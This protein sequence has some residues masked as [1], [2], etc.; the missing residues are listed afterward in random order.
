MARSIS[1]VRL[2]G[3]GKVG[4]LLAT[5]L[6]DSGFAVTAYDFRERRDLPFRTRTLDVRDKAALTAALLGSD[7]VVSCVPY[8]LTLPVA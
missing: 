8:H 2:L 7:A 3:L 6:I 1:D 4:E 5:L